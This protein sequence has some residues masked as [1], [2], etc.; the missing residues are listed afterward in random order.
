M[1]ARARNIRLQTRSIKSSQ[2]QKGFIY[3]IHLSVNNGWTVQLAIKSR[4]RI[5]TPTP[6]EYDKS[7]TQS[8][9]TSVNWVRK[10]IFPIQG[11]PKKTIKP[12]S[13]V[14]KHSWTETETFYQQ[15]PKTK[16]DGEHTYQSP[17]PKQGRVKIQSPSAL[18]SVVLPLAPMKTQKKERTKA[19]WQARS[20]QKAERDA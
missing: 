5:K 20:Q 8:P 17:Q 15:N 16:K 3:K 10:A 9:W 6:K 12:K 2:S 18:T 11:N 14:Y 19:V 13:R 1:N 4:N 7:H